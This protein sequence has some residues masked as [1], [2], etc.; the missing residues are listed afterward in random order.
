MAHESLGDVPVDTSM[1]S[2]DD[3]DFFDSGCDGTVDHED[4]VIGKCFDEDSHPLQKR[5]STN[6]ASDDAMAEENVLQRSNTVILHVDAH[7]H[8]MSDT[9]PG[10]TCQQES[11]EPAV[12]CSTSNAPV[13]SEQKPIDVTLQKERL[14]IQSPNSPL[15]D[16]VVIPITNHAKAADISSSEKAKSSPEQRKRSMK[17]RSSRR[18]SRRRRRKRRSRFEEQL[19]ADRQEQIVW[20]MENEESHTQS[21]PRSSCSTD[22]NGGRLSRSPLHANSNRSLLS[23]LGFPAWGPVMG[24]LE[25]KDVIFGMQSAS[26]IVNAPSKLFQDPGEHSSAPMSQR[27]R[28]K[29]RAQELLR[30]QQLLLPPHLLS[31]VEGK[32][33]VSPSPRRSGHPSSPMSLDEVTEWFPAHGSQANFHQSDSS[34]RFDEDSD[35]DLD[36]DMS[37]V[38]GAEQSRT[39]LFSEGSQESDPTPDF[40]HDTSDLFA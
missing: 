10:G 4:E 6:R 11:N 17:H 16:P 24:K 8:V 15:E 32:W 27:P 33:R 23:Q 25:P 26:E 36:P 37:S 3:A 29:S 22:G 2:D 38:H 9:D 7:D 39:Q 40:C 18:A 35:K 14:R 34:E 20:H 12:N 31:E 21:M 5:K 1:V 30:Q 19:L 13:F 28:S